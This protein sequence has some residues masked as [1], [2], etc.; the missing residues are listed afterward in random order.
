[1]THHQRLG[2][3]SLRAGPVHLYTLGSALAG[4][5]VLGS[6]LWVPLS[7]S[8]AARAGNRGDFIEVFASQAEIHSLQALLGSAEI[9]DTLRGILDYSSMWG[10]DTVADGG[11]FKHSFYFGGRQRNT[12]RLQKATVTVTPDPQS[13]SGYLL[14]C[15]SYGFQSAPPGGEPAVKDRTGL[16]IFRAA[17]SDEL[18]VARLQEFTQ[19]WS[20]HA[21]RIETIAGSTDR[22]LSF[23]ASEDAAGS[24]PPLAWRVMQGETQ[25]PFLFQPE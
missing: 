15:V 1:M 13:P 2:R 20:V 10:V 17:L 9:C 16:E 3:G 5:L 4:A 12:S 22:R 23:T 7:G 8:R 14:S 11:G 25:S 6:I 21:I 19:K 24:P 18:V